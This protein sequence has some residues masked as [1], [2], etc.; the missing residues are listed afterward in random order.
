[1]AGSATTATAP[2]AATGA[3]RSRRAI[4]AQ[5]PEHVVG[6][7]PQHAARARPPTATS[8]ISPT[9]EQAALAALDRAPAAGARGYSKQQSTRPQTL[10]YG[11]VDSPAGQA[12]WILEKFWAWTDCD[13]H[14]ENVLT[15]DELLDNVMLYWLPAP[16]RRRPGSTGRASGDSR[17]AEPVAVP[18]GVSIFPKEIFRPVPRA[19]RERLFTDIRYWNE[20]D[21]GG[22]F[23]AFEHPDAFVDELRAFF[24]GLR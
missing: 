22:H 8:A 4:G 19:G 14:P 7:P 13:G 6:H 23:A 15:R 3:R 18:T 12:A 2:R 20:L 10:G 11:L 5:D 17:A 16:A 9:A 1:M 24:R 21:R